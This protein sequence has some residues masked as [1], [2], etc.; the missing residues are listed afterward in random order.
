M[1]TQRLAVRN[2]LWEC[3]G[4]HVRFSTNEDGATFLVHHDKCPEAV[5]R[6]RALRRIAEATAAE[7][8]RIIALAVKVGAEYPDG[9]DGENCCDAECHYIWKPFADFIRKDKS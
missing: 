8:E 9:D 7:R 2:G 4:C 1:I 5:G 6:E 3:A